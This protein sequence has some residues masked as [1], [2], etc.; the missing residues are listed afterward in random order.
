MAGILGRVE[1]G[2]IVKVQVRK[3]LVKLVEETHSIPKGV[4]RLDRYAIELVS[5]HPTHFRSSWQGWLHG[6]VTSATALFRGV[7]GSEGPHA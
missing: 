6:P 3:V 7:P 5:L 2:E 1:I 4:R